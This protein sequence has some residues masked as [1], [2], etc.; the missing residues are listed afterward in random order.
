MSALSWPGAS[1]MGGTAATLRAPTSASR[2]T[3]S[4]MGGRDNSI[5]PPSTGDPGFLC[6][7][8]STSSW[9]SRAP[10]GSRLPWPTIRNAGAVSLFPFL[11]MLT[12]SRIFLL[13]VDQGVQSRRRDRGPALGPAVCHA[14]QTALQQRFL[15]LRRPDEPHREPDHERRTNVH[16]EQL[17]ERRR[18][19]S[20]HPH[21]PVPELPE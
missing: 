8:S 7:T 1:S 4:L 9:N 16:S 18:R 21:G 12:V 10:L 15:R 3:H 5:K 19:V 14:R 17:K 11:P 13:K 6:R 2:F 20:H